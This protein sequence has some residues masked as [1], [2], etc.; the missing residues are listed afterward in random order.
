MQ[1]KYKNSEE[2]TI[3]RATKTPPLEVENIRSEL[4]WSI[5]PNVV[6]GYYELHRSVDGSAFIYSGKISKRDI[7]AV[8]SMDGE[9]LQYKNVKN[10]RPI[11][12]FGLDELGQQYDGHSNS[13]KIINLLL[14]CLQGSIK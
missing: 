9:I 1:N 2:I 6:K 14:D 13:D 5:N 10:I 3:Y 7:L 8:F 12:P 11:T 4:S